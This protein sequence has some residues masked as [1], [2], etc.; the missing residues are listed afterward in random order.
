MRSPFEL[1]TTIINIYIL[2]MF[3]QLIL[4]GLISFNVIN[5]R[6]RFLMTVA[7]IL[8][9]LTEPVYRSVR[10]VMPH[11]GAVDITPLIIFLLLL[12]LRRLLMGLALPI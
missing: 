2:I 7:Q 8:Y 12:L 6:N 3:A 5:V 1:L 11:L 9:Q 4:S 10:N